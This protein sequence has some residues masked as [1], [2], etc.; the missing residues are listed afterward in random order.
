[1]NLLIYN[2]SKPISPSNYHYI[3]Q[4]IREITTVRQQLLKIFYPITFLKS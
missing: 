4:I 1:M 3:N 2:N